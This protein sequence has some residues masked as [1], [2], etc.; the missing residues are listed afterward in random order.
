MDINN[1]PT[2]YAGGY[3]DRGIE[4]NLILLPPRQSEI[5]AERDAILASDKPSWCV[6]V[7]LEIVAVE[8]ITPPKA[9]RL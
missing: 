1:S 8:R 6:V 3:Y 2:L 9:Q 4:E 5:D 7:E